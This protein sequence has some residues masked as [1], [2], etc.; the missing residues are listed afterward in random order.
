MKNHRIIKIIKA[1]NYVDA[2]LPKLH[3]FLHH[4]DAKTLMLLVFNIIHLI[5][6]K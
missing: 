1:N 6:S 2:I 4:Y 5:N 3:N